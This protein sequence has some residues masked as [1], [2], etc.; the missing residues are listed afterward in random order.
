MF[1]GP[2]NRRGPAAPTP[3]ER[4]ASGAPASTADLAAISQ[5]AYEG[6]NERPEQIGDLTLD[7]EL[8]TRRTAF[9]HNNATGETVQGNR[10]T[11][12]TSG[13]DLLA[14]AAI[15]TGTFGAS[16]RLKKATQQARAA[17]AKYGAAPTETGHSLGGTTAEYVA[18]K[19]GARSTVFNPG[20]SPLEPG[21]ANEKTTTVTTGVDPISYFSRY[22]AGM[23]QTVRPS[24][25]NVH[26]I[27]N[28]TKRR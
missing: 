7:P 8:S 5:A 4:A 21:R 23:H 9:Y 24:S 17:E 19:T 26:G 1:R 20:A 2:P 12:A 6:R 28:F 27:A 11:V 3:R 15:A 14:D 18:S 22:S 16:S 25:A 10:G 13:K